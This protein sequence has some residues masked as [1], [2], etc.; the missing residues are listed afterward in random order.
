MRGSRRRRAAVWAAGAA[1][2]LALC[3][4]VAWNLTRFE[5]RHEALTGPP[6]DLMIQPG[7]SAAEVEAVKGGLRAADRY[8]RSAL[9]RGADERVEVRIAREQGCRWPMSATG[10]AT[11]WAESHFLCVNTMSPTW[12]EVMAGDVTAAQSIIAHEHVHN[13]QGQV[14]CVRPSGEHEWLW[15]FEGMAVHLAY[16]AM[17]AEGRWKDG[18]AIDQIRRWGVDDPKLGPLQDYERTGTGLGDPAYALFHLATRS[19]V[20][21]SEGPR[22]LLEFCRETARGR[23]WREA[24]A[25]AFGLSPEAFYARFEEERRR[26]AGRPGA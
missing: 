22:S 19:L 15:L 18:E 17:V 23:P 24:F 5:A 14:G 1:V 11:A 13:L 9:G 12:R 2:L 16:Q 21:Q 6:A 25:G 8:L 3:G 7:V 20:E 26:V 10:P 4:G